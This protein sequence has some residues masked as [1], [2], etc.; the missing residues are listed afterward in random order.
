VEDAD[1]R[2]ERT[3]PCVD[4][5]IAGQK[6]SDAHPAVPDAGVR[7]YRRLVRTDKQFGVACVP[8]FV[9][10]CGLFAGRS[11]SATRRTRHLQHRDLGLW[12]CRAGRPTLEVSGGSAV[13][14]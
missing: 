9:W 13:V 11:W 4:D 7:S 2:D 1:R 10:S 8:K 14:E 5:A 12:R 6:M 3:S